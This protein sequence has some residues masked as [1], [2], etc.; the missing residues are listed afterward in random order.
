LVLCLQWLA[1]ALLPVV[2]GKST[3]DWLKLIYLVLGYP[4]LPG[5]RILAVAWFGVLWILGI[6]LDRRKA[7]AA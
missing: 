3:S 7:R 1:L 4:F 2:F 6:F 5:R